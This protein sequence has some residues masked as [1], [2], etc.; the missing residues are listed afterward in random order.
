MEQKTFKVP[1]IG[2]NGCVNTIKNEVGA[3]SGVQRVEGD[4]DSKMVTVEWGDPANWSTIKAK[5]EEIE[6]A[7]EA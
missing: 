7:P 4:V 5:L 3:L 1:N 2:C 6:Y